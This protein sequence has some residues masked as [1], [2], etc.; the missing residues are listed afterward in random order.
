[1]TQDLFRQDAY[2]TECTA[3]VTAI[4]A[5]GIVLDR[6]VFYP[7]GGG[8]AGDSGTLTSADGSAIA[9][10]DTRK[11]KAEDGTFTR[12]ICHQP[13]ADVLEQLLT[14]EQKSA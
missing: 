7:L 2:L 10:V 5:Q 4:T 6:T 8:Q 14:S 11:G 9:I 13:K 12:K 1:M 3:N